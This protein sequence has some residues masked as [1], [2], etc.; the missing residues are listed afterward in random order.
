[1]SFCSI[2]SIGTPAATRPTSG[3]LTAAAR[4][5][6]TTSSSAAAIPLAPDHAFALEVREVLVNRRERAETEVLS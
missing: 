3:S 4:R 5:C 1:M 2:G 6:C